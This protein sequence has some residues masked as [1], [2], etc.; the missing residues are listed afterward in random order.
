MS[1]RTTHQP[2]SITFGILLKQLRKRAGLTQRDLAAALSCSVSLVCALERNQRL[3]DL[4]TVTQR[5][6]PA[7]GLQEEPRLAAHLVE[8]AAQARGE[9]APAFPTHNPAKLSA[10]A[11]MRETVGTDSAHTLPIPPTHL[12]GRDQEVKLLCHRLHGHSGRLLTLVGPPGVGKTR[13]A[14]AV[15]ATMQPLYRDGAAFVDLAAVTDPALVATAMAAALQLHGS[16]AKA[17]EARLLEYLRRK[18]LLLLLD[19]FEQILPAAP[20]VA[21]LLSECADVRL[22]VTSRERLRLRAEQRYQVAPLALAAAVDLL[23]DRVQAL[24]ADFILTPANQPVSEAICRAVDCLPL[25]IE[26]IAAQSE[27]FALP[28]L[29]T[30]LHTQALDLLHANLADLPTPQRSLRLAIAQSYRL[31][32]P[33]TQ[34]LFRTLGVFAGGFAPA[35]LAH[36]GF[37]QHALQP[38]LDKS[39]IVRTATTALGKP[40]LDHQAL[41]EQPRF[42]LLATLRLF[43]REQL[44][45]HQEEAPFAHHAAYFLTLAE[46]A[47]EQLAGPEQLLWLTRLDR[48]LDNL[49]AAFHWLLLHEPVQAA[50]LAGALKEFWSLRGYYTEGRQWLT[51]A[52]TAPALPLDVR[53]RALLTAGQLVN[54]QGEPAAALALVEE[55]IALYRQARDHPA[56]AEALRVC[57][58]VHYDLHQRPAAIAALTESLQLYHQVADQDKIAAL[59]VSLVHIQGVQQLGYAQVDTIL[60]ASIAWFRQRGATDSL[61]SALGT[62]GDAALQLG[63]YAAAIALFREILT[64]ART[65]RLLHRQAWAHMGLSMSQRL[66][67]NPTQAVREAEAGLRLSQSLGDR[68]TILNGW[69]TLGDAYRAHGEFAAALAAYGSALELCQ[70][71]QN[72]H[73]AIHC[74]IGVAALA[75]QRTDY[76]TAV[77]LAAAA[78]SAVAGLSPFLTIGDQAELRQLPVDLQ[79]ALDAE[80]FAA[81][82]ASGATWSFAEALAAAQAFCER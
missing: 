22:I 33:H 58:W 34:Q 59:N 43:A 8:L 26:L 65:N 37:A 29:L 49:R 71:T 13:L 45:L 56:L 64:L 41:A 63:H 9:K 75:L 46:A 50:K 61:L 19:N 53:A 20:L 15:A 68:E 35:A 48:D 78:Q 77:P 1:P 76:G 32:I 82:W 47:A 28:Q 12:W 38:L 66:H 70:Q 54:R 27:L 2:P 24:D 5:Y 40:P 10:A 16:P 72:R 25:A 42:F 62:Q 17:P 39:L 4:Q 60:Q 18:E 30:H 7:L 80:T 14:Q 57:A 36:F 69:R 3:P 23:V 51:Q 11:K 74:W 79:V 55:S 44:A 52:L 21:K 6:L 31:L 67:G 73:Q 81:A